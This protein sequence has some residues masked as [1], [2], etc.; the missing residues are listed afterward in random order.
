V[1]RPFTYEVLTLPSP[2]FTPTPGPSG[3]PGFAIEVF[4][5][6]GFAAS[7]VANEVIVSDSDDAKVAKL[8][9][10]YGAREID[11]EVITD[12][13]GQPHLY[14]LRTAWVPTPETAN[15]SDLPRLAADAG[16]SG[17]YRFHT[18]SGAVLFQTYLRM[19]GDPEFPTQVNLNGF[20]EAYVFSGRYGTGEDC[21]ESLAG[22]PQVSV[23]ALVDARWNGADLTLAMVPDVVPVTQQGRK[24]IYGCGRLAD[25]RIEVRLFYVEDVSNGLDTCPRPVPVEVKGVP[26]GTYD[27]ID[28]QTGRKLTTL[29]TEAGD[30]DFGYVRPRCAQ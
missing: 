1:T 28:A 16:L 3:R 23:Q 8:Y 25:D 22:V 17:H 29:D 21:L 24:A 26:P 5:V 13:A 27:V 14:P 2:R 20:G 4:D 9:A 19:K 6:D 10:K 12:L 18:R 30:R 11:R 7:A 15:L